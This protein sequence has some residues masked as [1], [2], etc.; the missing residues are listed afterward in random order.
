MIVKTKW[1]SKPPFIIENNNNNNNDFI[2]KEW[3]E[4]NN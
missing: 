2:D 1:V 3:N 4:N